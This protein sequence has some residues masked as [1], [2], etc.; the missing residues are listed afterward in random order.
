MILV[1]DGFNLI[2]KFPEMEILMY[3][4]KLNNARNALLKKLILYKKKRKQDK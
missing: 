2:Y 4:N 3:E 1:V